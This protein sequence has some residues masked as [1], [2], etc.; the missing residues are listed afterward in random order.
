[1]AKRFKYTKLQQSQKT[2]KLSS[3]CNKVTTSVARF[4]RVAFKNFLSMFKGGSPQ[5]I[6]RDRFKEWHEDVNLAN[7]KVTYQ[8]G[9]RVTINDVSYFEKY[10]GFHAGDVA[11]ITKLI[12]EDGV[13]KLALFNPKWITAKDELGLGCVI[14]DPKKCMVEIVGVKSGGVNV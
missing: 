8:V 1:M 10:R 13:E 3:I 4:F 7:K 9:Q 14:V 11:K 5:D 12:N 2:S 6:M